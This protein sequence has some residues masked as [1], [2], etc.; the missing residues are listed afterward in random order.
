MFSGE[1]ANPPPCKSSMEQLGL[2]EDKVSVLMARLVGL[3]L[4]EKKAEM[5]DNQFV[6]QG[7]GYKAEGLIEVGFTV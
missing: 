1:I 6:P 4:W 2:V 7:L 5:E 3:I